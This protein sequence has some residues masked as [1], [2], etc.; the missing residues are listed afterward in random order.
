MVHTV[1]RRAHSKFYE[2][3]KGL[4]GSGDTGESLTSVRLK[5][6]IPVLRNAYVN[7]TNDPLQLG[8]VQTRFLAR[9]LGSTFDKPERDLFAS[10]STLLLHDLL[11]M[12]GVAPLIIHTL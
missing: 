1:K 8:S 9:M 10:A 3:E 11:C 7:P 4:E 2:E 6:P 5:V 12:A